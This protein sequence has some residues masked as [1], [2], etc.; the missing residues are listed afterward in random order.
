MGVLMIEF[1]QPWSI[2]IIQEAVNIN[3][4]LLSINK[5]W[6]DVEKSLTKIR[7]QEFAKQSS[8]RYKEKQQPSE[9]KPCGGCGKEPLRY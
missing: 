2:K 1:L 3:K 5:T 8:R 9:N 4:H 6:E 7:L